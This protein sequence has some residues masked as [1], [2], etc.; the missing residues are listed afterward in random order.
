M[1][2]IENGKDWGIFTKC[3]MTR[4]DF[5]K[6]A[7]TAAAGTAGVLGTTSAGSLLAAEGRIAVN[8]LPGA[9]LGRTGFKITRVSFGGILLTDPPVLQRAVDQGIKLVH[10]SP[11]YQNGRSMEALGKAFMSSKELRDKVVLALKVRPEKL[12]QC[13]KVL[14]TDYVDMLIPPM[15]SIEE[16]SSSELRENFEKARKAGK[17]GHM[18]FACHTQRPEI[19][20][21]M[22]EL[23]FYDVILMSYVDRN[24]PFLDSL[25]KARK[26]GIGILAM[27][28]LPKRASNNPGRK[29]QEL[30]GSLCTSIVERW[31]AHTVLASM[32]SFQA[33]EMYTDILKNKLGFYDGEAEERY[34]AGLDGN[35]CAMCG[36][37][38]G[39]CPQQGRNIQR[40][41]RYRMYHRDYGLTEYA[42]AKYS[43]LA[44]AAKSV[45]DSELA[46][47]ETV[48]TRKLPLRKM[49]A[50]ARLLLA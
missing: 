8:G 44:A 50:E 12:D 27:K 6:A 11:G 4:R 9:V 41:L 38:S 28:G 29:E 36:T 35:Y 39:Q 33:V 45:S 47:C 1:D 25:S 14:G 21:K 20:D 23:G 48:C 18:G 15:D 19:I 10:T 46:L 17:C 32:G 22:V 16:I 43:R 26:A 24:K 30:I 13:L 40:I 34:W 42:R 7:S 3:V 2:R 5:L 37:C 49:V 31:H